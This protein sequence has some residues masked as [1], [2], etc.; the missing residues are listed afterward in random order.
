MYTHLSRSHWPADLS[1]AL[2]FPNQRDAR[3]SQHGEVESM[4]KMLLFHANKT[5][6]CNLFL[7]QESIPFSVEF[8]YQWLV[9][10]EI[11]ASIYEEITATVSSPSV[12]SILDISVAQMFTSR[13]IQ[14]QRR[15]GS[16]CKANQTSLLL[17][18][19]EE[20]G[21]EL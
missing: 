2:V 21:D 6:F 17:D 4:A 10:H 9:T 3:N 12:A 16:P 14:Q 7:I 8:F 19:G 13:T 18:E 11:E 20:E 5:D 1:C 15:E